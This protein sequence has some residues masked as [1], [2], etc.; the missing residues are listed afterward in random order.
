MA[1][2]SIIHLEPHFRAGKKDVEWVSQIY[3]QYLHVHV[4]GVS[5]IHDLIWIFHMQGFLVRSSV[6]PESKLISG[7]ILVNCDAIIIENQTTPSSRSSS[8]LQLSLIILDDPINND[9]SN[10]GCSD[11]GG[12]Q[13]VGNSRCNLCVFSAFLFWLW[14]KRNMWK[15]REDSSIAE[16][17]LTRD[18]WPTWV[19][20]QLSWQRTEGWPSGR[21]TNISYW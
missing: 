3:I 13:N 12:C 6:Q 18:L 4:P 14:I 21:S 15:H 20:Q 19:T 8:P 1:V 16:F 9:Q 5:N 10:S 11:R 7:R 17:E 2:S